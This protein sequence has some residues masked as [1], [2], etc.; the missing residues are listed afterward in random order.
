MLAFCQEM[1]LAYPFGS[2]IY[3]SWKRNI[4]FGSSKSE[5]SNGSFCVPN[6]QDFGHIGSVPSLVADNE[7]AGGVDLRRRQ[8][9]RCEEGCHRRNHEEE[10]MHRG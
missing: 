1:P 2:V 8:D 10:Y 6:T 4:S 5:F 7:A 9:E 3:C